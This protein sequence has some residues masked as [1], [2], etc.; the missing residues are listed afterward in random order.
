[1]VIKKNDENVTLP[2]TNSQSPWKWTIPKG[3]EYSN[4]INMSGFRDITGY[5][6][7]R[8]GKFLG[9]P[10][11]PAETPFDSPAATSLRWPSNPSSLQHGPRSQRRPIWFLGK[12][13]GLL[14]LA[15]EIKCWSHELDD[16]LISTVYP[17]Q[18]WL[19]IHQYI[20]MCSFLMYHWIISHLS[21]TIIEAVC[22]GASVRMNH[23]LDVPHIFWWFF[24]SLGQKKIE[25]H[26]TYFKGVSMIWVDPVA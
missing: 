4:Y 16:L 12:T 17:K 10:I 13:Y 26:P 6:S 7:F 11:S 22:Q 21:I 25:K 3:N 20:Q 5:V 19:S 14:G 24:S 2:K 18:S 23:R 8:E 1:M 15:I 9:L